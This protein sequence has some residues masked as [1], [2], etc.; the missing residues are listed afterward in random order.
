MSIQIGSARVPGNVLLAPMAG[1]TDAPFR[2]QAL[3]FGAPGCVSE[4]VAC[5]A[6]SHMRVDMIRKTERA[7][8]QSTCSPFILQL[9]GREAKWL[10]WGAHLARDAGV[11][12]I[13][14]NMGCPAKRVTGGLAG[15]ALMRDADL[16]C[17]LV[18][19]C[20]EGAGAI[21][22]T[23]KM[24]L[25]WDDT[26]HQAPELAERFERLGV[27]ALSIHGRT[28][29]QFYQGHADWQAVRAVTASTKL[30]VFVNGDIVDPAT[31]RAALAASG[32]AGVMIGR[33]SLARPWIIGE[34]ASALAGR[35]YETPSL[36]QIRDALIELHTDCLE[37][38]GHELGIRIARKHLAA[39]FL[40]FPPD[41]SP[42][43][44]IEARQALCRMTDPRAIH[45]AI[46]RWFDKIA[47]DFSGRYAPPRA[48]EAAEW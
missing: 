10:H 13:D 44:Q 27:S 43:A 42:E 22:V 18:E 23:V 33:A 3:A 20:L 45:E 28:R 35:A 41:L 46:T 30:P 36:L 40:A 37:F 15:A 25:G 2:R 4:M 29:C 11:D 19:A 8:D 24:R 7:Q 38:Y 6:L 34:V 5:E 31:A 17:R 47:P 39:R 21:P 14:I 12:I 9:A 26:E 16:A 1:V 32:A 48:L